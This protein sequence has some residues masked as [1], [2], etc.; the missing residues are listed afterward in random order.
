MSEGKNHYSILS[1]LHLNFQ[2][3][4][5]DNQILILFYFA[6][7]MYAL[8]LFDKFL[9]MCITSSSER[10][11]K[12]IHYHENEYLKEFNSFFC[13]FINGDDENL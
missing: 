10:L 5:S 9:E 6:F 13:F 7:F 8:T 4:L 12:N 3:C 11:Q 2:N 1:N